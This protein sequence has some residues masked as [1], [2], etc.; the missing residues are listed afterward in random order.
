LTSTAEQQRNPL[1]NLI[2]SFA[3]RIQEPTVCARPECA[4]KQSMALIHNRCYFG[5]KQ[6][7]RLQE[8]PDAIPEGETPHTVTLC[9]FDKLV[10]VAKPG[11]R[12]EVTG[13]FRAAPVRSSPIHRTLKSL[14]RVRI[15][16][17]PLL[18]VRGS[19]APCQGLQLRCSACPN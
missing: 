19:L 7:V 8:T 16:A 1:L 9:F 14:Y 5:N 15:C 11:D 2:I 6:T 3:G 17:L 18:R 10:D 13:I 4:A 12:V